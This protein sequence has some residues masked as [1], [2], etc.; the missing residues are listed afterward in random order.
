M[1]NIG[2]RTRAIIGVIIEC[3]MTASIPVRFTDQFISRCDRLSH[4]CW[5]SRWRAS[6]CPFHKSGARRIVLIRVR[7]VRLASGQNECQADNNKKKPL[8][9]HG[10]DSATGEETPS[11]PGAPGTPG[12]ENNPRWTQINADNRQ[13]L[14]ADTNLPNF[15]RRCAQHPVSKSAPE[16]PHLG[17]L[18]SASICVHLRF[19]SLFAFFRVHS[20][21]V[22]RVRSRWETSLELRRSA[23][24]P[25]SE[26]SGG[27]SN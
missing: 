19:D 11:T 22:T 16:R 17:F 6:E 4:N 5:R 8:W 26:V 15:E 1:E 27:G 21:L 10:R 14:R 12:T 24:V 13:E 2:H 18:L 25:G 3:L 23:S 20:R 9:Q 7:R